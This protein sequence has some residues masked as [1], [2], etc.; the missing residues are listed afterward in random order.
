MRIMATIALGAAFAL[1][2]ATSASAQSDQEMADLANNASLCS[3]MLGYTLD[4]N[5]Y[6]TMPAGRQ[7][8]EQRP[9]WDQY[10][11]DSYGQDGLQQAYNTAAADYQRLGDNYAASVIGWCLRNDPDSIIASIRQWE[12]TRT[13]AAQQQDSYAS[14]SPTYTPY[15]PPSTPT[16]APTPS[17][18]SNESEIYKNARESTQQT[19]CNAGWGQCQ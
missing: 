6:G 10:V 11:V 13:H 7:A 8:A 15:T 9:V 19:Y 16:Y 4:N 1:G 2:I 14:S 18:E 5:M 12:Y 17:M 3:G